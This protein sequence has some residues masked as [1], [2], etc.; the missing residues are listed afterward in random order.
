MKKFT[1]SIT[2]EAHKQLL[3]LQLERKI[4]G[5][6]VTALSEMAGELLSKYL[7][8]LAKQQAST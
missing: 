8:E 6:A 3:K 2:D 1:I 4:S 7:E 5:H